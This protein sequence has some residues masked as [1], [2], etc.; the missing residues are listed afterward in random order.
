LFGAQ[1]N[2]QHKQAISC[3]DCVDNNNG[4]SSAVST[5]LHVGDDKLHRISDQQRYVKPV[6][7]RLHY[8]SRSTQQAIQYDVARWLSSC[9]VTLDFTGRGFKQACA[10]DRPY[11][12]RPAHVNKTKDTTR[13]QG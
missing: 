10:A 6:D 13:P 1:R 2:F 8:N 7:A 4:K 12:M 5:T 3:H 9:D 11:N